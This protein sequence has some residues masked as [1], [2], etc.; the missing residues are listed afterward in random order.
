MEYDTI[1]ID[2][3]DGDTHGYT[4]TT[5]LQYN[6]GAG[7]TDIISVNRNTTGSLGWDASTFSIS[8]ITQSQA[9]NVQFRLGYTLSGFPV[10]GEDFSENTGI[11]GMTID[12]VT[13]DANTVDNIDQNRESWEVTDW[14]GD[15]TT[16]QVV[17][18]SSIF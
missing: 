17:W 9:E 8:G 7:W 11:W 13:G 5:H 4:F 15:A 10:G 1:G 16:P 3:I 2:W 12:S 14:Y 6:K 18:Y